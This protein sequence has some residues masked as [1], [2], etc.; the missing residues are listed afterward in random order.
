VM[1]IHRIVMTVLDF[2]ELGA[3]SVADAIV[4]TRYPNDCIAPHIVEIQTR[5]IG[6]WSDHHPLN[7][8]ST[9]QAEIAQLFGGV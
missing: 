5:D 8:A 4:N 2:D 3:D 7:K 1:Q 6:E 9:A